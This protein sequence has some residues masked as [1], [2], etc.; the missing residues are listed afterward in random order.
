MAES[1]N[2]A[3]A[4]LAHLGSTLI[5]TLSDSTR[6]AKF[7]N[8]RIAACRQALLRLHL[9]NFAVARD[10]LT[11]TYTTVLGCAEKINGEIIVY[12]TAHGL[13][14]GQWVRVED[15][16]GTTE[17]NGTWKITKIDA[18]YFSLDGSDFVTAW[19]SGGTF[20]RVPPHG[21]SFMHRIPTDLLRLVGVDEG[22]TDYEFE[23]LYILTDAESIDIKYI[24]NITDETLFDRLFVEGFA[25]Y[26]AWTIC[27][28]LTQSSAKREQLFQEFKLL[29]PKH[30]FVDATENPSRALRAEDITDAHSSFG[31]LFVR[32]PMT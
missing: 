8:L 11:A 3:N 1:V 10:T 32:D 15:V 6:E 31:T 13:T 2:V 17:A 18:D 7:C 16:L 22:D 24:A 19:T 25:L 12:A 30:K 26:L 29:F 27:E 23:G 5:T 21:W 14:T 20:L 28:V 9:W 4:A